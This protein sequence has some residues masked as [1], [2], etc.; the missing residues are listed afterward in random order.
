MT[1]KLLA[2]D[3]WRGD[4]ILTSMKLRTGDPV[5]T[6]SFWAPAI[7]NGAI[8]LLTGSIYSHAMLVSG[9]DTIIEFRNHLKE[10]SLKSA[11]TDGGNTPS[12]A[13]VF[14]HLNSNGHMREQV[15]RHARTMVHSYKQVDMKYVSSVWLGLSAITSRWRQEDVQGMVVCSSFCATAYA[16]AGSPLSK[17]NSH[18]MAPGDIALCADFWTGSKSRAFVSVPGAIVSGARK[19]VARRA[20]GMPTLKLVGEI[21]PHVWA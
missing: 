12:V 21:S 8:N 1:A 9:T 10:K 13:H 16:K 4:I 3:L 15:M 14:R 20:W 19:W 5:D 17:I 2:T 11:L 7:E 6:V 18:S